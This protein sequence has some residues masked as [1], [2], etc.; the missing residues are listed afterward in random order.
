MRWDEMRHITTFA[1][2]V[3]VLILLLLLI[4]LI[5]IIY[6]QMNLIDKLI[7]IYGGT[8]EQKRQETHTES[9]P[10]VTCHPK[11][12]Y[13]GCIAVTQCDRLAKMSPIWM[14]S[15]ARLSLVWS[16]FSHQAPSV[17]ARPSGSADLPPAPPG[18]VLRRH[19]PDASICENLSR[20]ARAPRSSAN[21]RFKP[22][23]EERW[24]NRKVFFPE[25]IGQPFSVL[26]WFSFGFVGRPI[27]NP[28]K[29]ALGRNIQPLCCHQVM[30]SYV[31]NPQPYRVG[32]S[33]ISLEPWLCTIVI[34]NPVGWE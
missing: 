18:A 27:F 15:T 12:L 11:K 31:A 1:N 25:G 14:E 30:G 28:T 22:R 34:A 24:G 21:L 10:P 9:Q 3:V 23:G 4:I 7:N 8:K 16:F 19:D 2:V 29:G 17:T 6:I 32:G 26:S 13:S 20:V 5:I 33:S